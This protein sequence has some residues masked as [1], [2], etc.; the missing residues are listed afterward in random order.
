MFSEGRET[1]R[2]GKRKRKKEG[3]R[4]RG[5]Y[6][7]FYVN[8]VAL[9][10]FATRMNGRRGHGEENWESIFESRLMEMKVETKVEMERI[11]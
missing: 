11:L 6:I 9:C 3:R 5:V 7:W 8:F 10:F 2:D 1:R 4:S